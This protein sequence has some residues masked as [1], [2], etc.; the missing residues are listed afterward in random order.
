MAH[1]LTY[2]LLE[3]NKRRHVMK[4]IRSQF[5]LPPILLAAFLFSGCYSYYASLQAQD[6]PARDAWA[7]DTNGDVVEVPPV[8]VFLNPFMFTPCAPPVVYPVYDWYHRCWIPES[9]FDLW[10]YGPDVSIGFQ[11][12]LDWRF[13]LWSHDWFPVSRWHMDHPHYR[14]PR[15]YAYPGFGHDWDRRP[16]RSRHT[17]PRR[18]DDRGRWDDQW[19]DRSDDRR[20]EDGGFS[21]RDN[22]WRSDEDHGKGQDRR[23]DRPE[24]DGNRPFDKQD[25][26]RD[27]GTSGTDRRTPPQSSPGNLHDTIRRI[28]VGPTETDRNGS[29]R[30]SNGHENGTGNGNS[31][32]QRRREKRSDETRESGRNRASSEKPLTWSGKTPSFEMPSFPGNRNRASRIEKPAE[33]PAAP[34]HNEQP[35]FSARSSDRGDSNR[36]KAEIRKRDS[37]EQTNHREKPDNRQGGNSGSRHSRR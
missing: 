9:E 22:G 20:H 17:P 21:G 12:G 18:Q 26:P 34:N 13:S 2:V 16:P 30:D 33:R 37:G 1:H 5:L 8:V 15:Y 31:G 28:V 4:P 35:R 23:P 19:D 10:L 6:W 29:T 3:E 11:W 32:S 14:G 24:K 36:P 27:R 25:P 7:D